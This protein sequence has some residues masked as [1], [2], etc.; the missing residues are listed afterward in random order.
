MTLNMSGQD[1]GYGWMVVA[2]CIITQVYSGYG[3][4]VVGA[5]VTT[6]EYGGYG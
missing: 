4:M 1:G 2:A 6:Q 5:C 3:W